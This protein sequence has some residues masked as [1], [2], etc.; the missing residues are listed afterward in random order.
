[1]HRYKTETSTECTTIMIAKL[2]VMSD[3]L[4]RVY[5]YHDIL[6]NNLKSPPTLTS[7][8]HNLWSLMRLTD[9]LEANN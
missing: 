5:N 3:S 4:C 8:Q 2:T 6:I 9:I 1:M 7:W